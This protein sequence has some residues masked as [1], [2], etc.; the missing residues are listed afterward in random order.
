MKG[1][2]IEIPANHEFFQAA[3]IEFQDQ[4]DRLKY[5]SER[6]IYCPD[7]G[8]LAGEHNG[9]HFFTIGQ[10][11]GLGVGGKKE[12]LFVLGTDVT[13]NI[14]YAGQGK[15]HP[16]LYSKALF[17][18]KDEIHWVREDLK[19]KD[20]ETLQLKA[21]IRYRQPLKEAVLY[22]IEEGLFIE[23]DEPQSAVTPG[24]FVAWYDGEELL[25]SGV[26]S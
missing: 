1:K 9:A 6:K 14:I 19:L 16:G 15:D 23:F 20:G 12:P 8:T 24:Q 11:K 21:R 22:M 26:I 3:T 18:K 4:K 10:R 5:L 13:E 25:G 7:D 2:I 17:V